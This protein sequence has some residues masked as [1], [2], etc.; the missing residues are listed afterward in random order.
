MAQ[1]RSIEVKVGI[2]ILVSLVILGGFILVMGGLSF[3]KTYALYVDFDNP[4]GL[5]PGAPVRLAGIKIGS[6]GEM[7]FMGGKIDEKRSCVGLSEHDGSSAIPRL[8]GR[9]QCDFHDR[10]FSRAAHRLRKRRQS[11]TF[12]RRWPPS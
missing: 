8:C 1:E 11:D 10:C 9:L 2:L 7:K 12:A 4:G 6:V 5:Q 3:E